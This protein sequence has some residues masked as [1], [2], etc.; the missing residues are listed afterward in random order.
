[1]E[2][3]GKKVIFRIPI[4]SQLLKEDKIMGNFTP[5]LHISQHGLEVLVHIS[6]DCQWDGNDFKYSSAE[7]KIYRNDEDGSFKQKLTSNTR[8]PNYY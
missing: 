6:T 5:K 4:S 1:M 8:P 3:R 7:I 2:T